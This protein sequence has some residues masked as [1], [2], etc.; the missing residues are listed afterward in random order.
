MPA[1]RRPVALLQWRPPADVAQLVEHFTRNEGVPGSNP[2]VGF[3]FQSGVGTD[4][5]KTEAVHAP[6]SEHLTPESAP[7]PGAGG[8]PCLADVVGARA[9]ASVPSRA[10]DGRP[11]SP[12]P[13]RCRAG[14]R[15]RRG[16]A[17]IR[18]QRGE[19]VPQVVR[20][21]GWHPGLGLRAALEAARS[22]LDAVLACAGSCEKRRSA[23]TGMEDGTV[24]QR[25]QER[26]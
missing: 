19:G 1:E 15:S 6:N 8:G 9:R 22:A 5:N 10:C 14:G 3:P 26:D 7:W 24:A 4:P 23:R 17:G 18:R 20:A 12:R 11:C 2:G 21:S 13:S 25:V 16:P